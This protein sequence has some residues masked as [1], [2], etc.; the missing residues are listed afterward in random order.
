MNFD[1]IYGIRVYLELARKIGLITVMKYQNFEKKILKI[2]QKTKIEISPQ[3]RIRLE[4]YSQSESQFA[5][6]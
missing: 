5:T 2:V 6:Q 1:P 4:I 3:N